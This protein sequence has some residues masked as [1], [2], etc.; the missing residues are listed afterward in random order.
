M[1]IRDSD[2]TANGR[3][4]GANVDTADPRFAGL[5]ESHH[6]ALDP[7]DPRYKEVKAADAIVRERDRRRRAKDAAP[8]RKKSDA[9]DVAGAGAG[10]AKSKAGKAKDLELSAMV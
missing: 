8:K 3:R 2:E 4:S 6:F 7:T 5:F 10:D 1:C 9:G